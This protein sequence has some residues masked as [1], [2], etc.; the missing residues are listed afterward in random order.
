MIVLD[1]F[2]KYVGIPWEKG[3]HTHAA[4]DCWGL[5]CLV[6]REQFG[7]TIRDYE[8]SKAEGGEL[9]HIIHVETHSERWERVT[10]PAPGCVAVMHCRQTGRPTHVGVY[11]GGDTI[12]HALSGCS[13]VNIVKVL[14][15]IFKKIEFFRHVG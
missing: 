14:H 2:N 15:R 1:Q 10:S 6:L 4:A 3:G 7:V 11:L 8:G 12:L 13:S 5:V 9:S